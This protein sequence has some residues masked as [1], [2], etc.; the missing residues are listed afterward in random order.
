M[1]FDP[2]T[3]SRIRH[4]AQVL[5]LN[6]NGEVLLVRHSHKAAVYPDN[7]GVLS[8]WIA[9]GGGI[10][11]GERPEDAA[12]RELREETGIEIAGVI[13]HILTREVNQYYG[14]EFL[15]QCEQFFL[16]HYSGTTLPDQF[17]P[18][19][20]EVIVDARWWT[21]SE[22]EQ[23]TEIFFPIGIVALIRAELDGA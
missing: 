9:P 21:I 12:K 22:I 3:P 4:V 7:P 5:L 8:Y 14:A 17:V 23:S 11:P 16:A 2:T 19:E 13:R 20:A 1:T 6:E 10:E 18:I 15:T